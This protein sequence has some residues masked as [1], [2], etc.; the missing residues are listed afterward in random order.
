M[1]AFSFSTKTLLLAALATIGANANP[2][3]NQRDSADLCTD[4]KCD[5]GTTCK[6][7][8][9]KPNCVPV[10]GEKCGNNVCAPGQTCC[11]P[12]CGVCTNPGEVCTPKA[13]EPTIPAP[14]ETK[15]GP[16]TCAAG[17]E[18]CNESCGICVKPGH[19]CTQQYC[20]LEIPIERQCG[21]KVCPEG[22]TCCNPSC[23]I[24]TP[25]GFACLQYICEE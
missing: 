22:T 4:V 7:I 5:V 23:G 20:A 15:C 10:E 16:T 21:K 3:L 2:I 12:S 17:L 9:G 11:N 25:P 8:D 18:C 1:P 14:G 19:G 6:V 24:C 13:C